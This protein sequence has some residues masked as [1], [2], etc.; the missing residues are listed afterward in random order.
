MASPADIAQVLSSTLNPDTNIRITAELNLSELLKN[1]QSALSLAQ[2]ILSQDAESSLRQ[3]A[4]IVLRKYVKEHWSPIFQ[5]FRGNAPPVE[6]KGQIR[7]VVFQGLSDPDRKI[8]SLCA[9]ALSTIANAD[10]PDEY[11]DLLNH[12]IQ[13]L[14]SGSSNSIHGAMEVFTEFVR[15][16]LT[17]DQLLPVMRELLPVLMAILSANEQHSPLTRARTISVFRQ[18]V[19]ALY[20]VKDQHPQAVKEAA[21]NVLP[22]WLDA[23]K[24]LL[25][26]DPQHDV[27]GEHWDGL[28]IRVQIFKTLD[29][30]HTSFP[31]V[32]AP[33]L[34]AYLSASLHHLQALYPTFVQYYLAD[35]ATVPNSSEGVPIELH[36]L[37]APLVDFVSAATRRSKARVSFEDGTLGRLVD[38]LVQWAQMTRENEEEWAADANLFISQEDDD[39]QAY[40]IRVAVFDL[41]ASLLSNAPTQTVSALEASVKRIIT[42]T[43]QAREAGVQEWWRPLEGALATLGSQA[44]QI[45]DITNDEVDSGRPKPLDIEYLLAQVIPSLLTLSAYPFLQGRCLFF[46]SRFAELLPSDV[47]GQYLD[48]AVQVIESSET[49]IPFKVSAVKSIQHFAQYIQDSQLAIVP[50]IARDLGPF[51]LETTEDTLTLVLETLSALSD[52]GSGTWLT[53]D[54]ADALTVALLDV[55]PKN[56]RD[57][58]FLSILNDVLLSIASSKTPGIYE[59]TIKQALP[60][61]TTAIANAS[62]EESWVASSALELLGSLARGAPEAGLGDGFFAAIAPSVFNCLKVAE[63]RDVLQNGV[64]LL[65]LVVRKDVNQLLSWTGTDGQTGTANVLAVVARLLQNQDESGGLVI[66]DLIIHLLRRAGESVLPVLP[67]LLQAMLARMQSAQTATFLQSLVVPFAFLLHGQRDIVLDLLEAARIGDD[68]RVGLDV[69]L[70]TWCENAA[71]FQGFWP[72]RISALALC[73]LLR[74]ERAS[75]QQ[76]IVKGDIIITAATKNTIM[77]RSKT[78]VEPPQ[79]TKVPFPVKALKLLLHELQTNGEA[80]SMAAPSGLLD[81]DSDDGASEWADEEKLEQTLKEDEFAFLSDIVGVRGMSFDN[82]DVLADND[83]EDLLKDPVSQIDLRAHVISFIKECAARDANGFGAL[84]GQLNAEEMVV[85][86]RVVQE[87]Q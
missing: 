58:I 14:S 47:R 46:A 13:L 50:R 45:S 18:C 27:I 5:Q 39:T 26:L 81:A 86:Q 59:T 35:N 42:E 20:M 64:L 77:T 16:D 66:G 57:P 21:A 33:Y 79:F 55:W 19:E 8:R 82:D 78:R 67:D 44:E 7:Q 65:T 80:A 71:T 62:A 3:S 10:W 2:L 84:V 36:K 4:S 53:P 22:V 30:V 11:P 28:D 23:F 75:L 49:G 52:V 15:A 25:E 60:R 54:L 73:D 12:L 34:P 32:I 61:L 29:T 69:L 87:Q 70:N 40:S 6:V 56:I 31:R 83:D 43:N 48:A 74:A 85:V 24:V 63:D 68:A 17:E 38:T 76:V 37:I 51:L 41:L 72:T 1:P 9:H